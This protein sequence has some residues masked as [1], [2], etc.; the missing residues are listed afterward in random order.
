MSKGGYIK[1]LWRD[2]DVRRFYDAF[3]KEAD[4]KIFLF[5]QREGELFVTYARKNGNYKDHTGNLRSSVGYAIVRE[6]KVVSKNL[7]LSRDGLVRIKGLTKAKWLIDELARIYIKGW[8]LLGV[9]A[10]EYAAAVEAIEGKNV[11][12]AAVEYTENDTRSMSRIL[13]DKL[14]KKGL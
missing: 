12:S 14:A 6:G 10:M 2:S 4:R 11:I 9:A 13:F 7:E 1:P 8:T 5:L 3:N